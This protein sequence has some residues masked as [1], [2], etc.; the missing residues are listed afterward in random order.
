M[1]K[2]LEQYGFYFNWDKPQ[3]PKGIEKITKGGNS[4]TE[5]V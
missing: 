3:A 2:L 5:S 1:V 4:L